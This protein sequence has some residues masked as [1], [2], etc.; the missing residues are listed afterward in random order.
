MQNT[1][2]MVCARNNRT[3]MNDHITCSI[4]REKT[5]PAGGMTS[6]QAMFLTQPCSL[7]KSLNPMF[8]NERIVLT[9]LNSLPQGVGP[10]CCFRLSIAPMIQ[11]YSVLDE[12]TKYHSIKPFLI[13][14][15]ACTEG[16]YA[17][18]SCKF[19]TFCAHQEPLIT[20]YCQS[21]EVYSGSR[22]A[23]VYA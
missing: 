18:G 22:H 8:A 19:L 20:T 10:K 6:P 23:P 15:N 17:L 7:T 21:A 9:R 13:V 16:I 11:I 4:F 3:I 2:K 5:Q 1:K 14:E 12:T